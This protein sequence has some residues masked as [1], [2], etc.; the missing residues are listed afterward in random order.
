MT[1][2][3]TS[4]DALFLNPERGFFTVFELPGR[5]DFSEVRMRGYTLA[6]V[7]IHLDNWRETDIPEDVLDDLNMNMAN[8]RQAG[9]KAFLRFSYN[10]GPYPNSE[11]DASKTI[12]LRHIQQL[13]PLLKNNVDIIAWLEAGFI[14]AWGEW[15]TSTNG[16]DNISDKKVILFALLD[17]LPNSRVVQVRYPADI[18]EIFPKALT[19]DLAFNGSNQSRV[20][21][22]NDCFLSSNTDVGTYEH[23]GNITIERDQRYLGEL[24]RF[25]PMS[26]ETCIPNP[27]RSNCPTTLQE[28]ALLHFTS[29]NELYHKGI[30]QSWKDDGCFEEISRSLGY[31]L[32]LINA[33][34]DEQ[35]RPSGILNLKITIHNT[36]FASFINERPLYIVLDGVDRYTVKVEQIDPRRWEGRQS[37]SFT[38]QLRMPSQIVKGE[39]RL[40][41]WLPDA[42]VS[43]QADSRYAVRFANE[44][45]WD[46]AD[47][48]NVL[49]NVS[50][51]QTPDEEAEPV[52]QL[53]VINA[54]ASEPTTLPA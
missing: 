1:Y 33:D 36:G 20:G 53:S 29:I 43:L 10:D 25:T 50:I 12:I 40:A 4:S 27:P 45:V 5:P 19:V 32:T 3:Y 8:M 7:N 34:F 24:T 28:M 23:A 49:G 42:A 26:G 31:R 22:H 14:G 13:T 46:E 30:I 37:V 18:I 52:S 51:L 15:H 9:I 11:P 35:V 48:F 6:R 44:K 16:L 17:A 2:T 41:L 21:H 54:V 47:G 38:V 39:Y